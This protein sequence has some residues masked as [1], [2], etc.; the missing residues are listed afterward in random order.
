MFEPIHGSAF[1]ITGKGIANPIATFWTAAMMLEHL[2]EP[3]AAKQL[4]KAI[5]TVTAR[6][7]FTPDLGGNATTAEVT[8]AVCTLL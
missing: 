1:D 8:K 7:I 2:G 3:A 4:M 6:Q 5:E